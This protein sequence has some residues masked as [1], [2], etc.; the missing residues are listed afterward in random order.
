MKRSLLLLKTLLNSTL[1]PTA[2]DLLSSGL[3]KALETGTDN[4][5]LIVSFFKV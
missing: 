3:V 5:N 4:A 1:T 2:A